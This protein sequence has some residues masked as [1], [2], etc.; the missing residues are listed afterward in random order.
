MAANL[1]GTLPLRPPSA[2]A[3][4]T[5]RHGASIVAH[6]GS[7]ASEIGVC[8][9]AAGL[10][11]RSDLGRVD[12]RGRGTWLDHALTR[13]LGTGAPQPGHAVHVA[14]SWCC[15]LT[16]DRAVLLAPPSA[17]SRWRGLLRM[18]AL[19]GDPIAYDDSSRGSA[20]V[21]LLGPR[22]R[23]VIDAAGLPGELPVCAIASGE[24]GGIATLLVRESQDGFLLAF[25]S[26]DAAAATHALLRIGRPFG[27]AR[28]GSEALD[29]LRIAR[30]SSSFR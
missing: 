17:L 1:A 26:A 22:A 3:V 7:V 5:R 29:R 2:N 10:A 11:E 27:V 21:S 14:D 28:V 19:S 15:R 13:A 30:P 23:A 16:A 8:R 24:L 4:L 18:A 9:K 6:Y 12:L 20:A 25:D